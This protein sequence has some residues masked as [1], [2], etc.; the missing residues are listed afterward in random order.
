MKKGVKKAKAAKAKTVKKGKSAVQSSKNVNRKKGDSSPKAGEVDWLGSSLGSALAITPEAVDKFIRGSEKNGDLINQLFLPY[1]PGQKADFGAARAAAEREE[2]EKALA[3]VKP[4]SVLKPKSWQALREEEEKK[5]QPYSTWE[6]AQCAQ[7]PCACYA[8]EVANVRDNYSQH[9]GETE[10]ESEEEKED[11][12]SSDEEGLMSICSSRSNLDIGLGGFSSENKSGLEQYLECCKS[13]SLHPISYLLDNLQSEQI[14]LGKHL[15]GTR[16]AIAVAR[17]LE[18]NTY[19]HSLGLSS[20]N[21]GA[22]AGPALGQMLSTNRNLV[23]LDL[24]DNPLGNSGGIAIAQAFRVNRSL[25]RLSLANTKLGDAAADAL[26]NSLLFS[27]SGALSYLDL[28]QNLITHKSAQ[29][30]AE[31][32]GSNASLTHINLSW[33][34]LKCEGAAA[35]ADGVSSNSMTSLSFLNLAWNGIGDGAADSL[36]GMIEASKKLKS[37]DLRHNRLTI[38]SAKRI[39]AVLPLTGALRT[40]YL[41]F[42][43]LGSDGCTCLIQSLADNQTLRV[44]GL[45]NALGRAIANDHLTDISLLLDGILEHRDAFA[46]VPLLHPPRACDVDPR[47]LFS[48]ESKR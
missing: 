33:N 26:S 11:Q 30:L 22:G 18:Q 47:L 34:N 13:L 37:L 31:V 40:L 41:G 24:S 39:A 6:C 38:V 10:S 28:S 36:A 12:G 17:A 20:S 35:I 14:S 32:F 15:I 19:V 46:Q 16:G 4:W 45:E 5:N 1:G 2:R 29:A 21:I 42:N 43:T 48:K 23:A 25:K 44:L 9:S 3:L 7:D 8:L 27:G